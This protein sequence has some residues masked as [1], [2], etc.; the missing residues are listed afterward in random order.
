MKFHYNFCFNGYIL[1]AD[2]KE[3]AQM[4]NAEVSAFVQRLRYSLSELQNLPMPTIAAIDGA[5][6]G[7]GLEMAL[8]C[9]LR[10]ACE[11]KIIRTAILFISYQLRALLVVG[12]LSCRPTPSLARC[13]NILLFLNK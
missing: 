8:A 10:V 4:S 6:L 7:G 1:G 11:Y 9:D 2:L 12:V 3:R 5:A 13:S